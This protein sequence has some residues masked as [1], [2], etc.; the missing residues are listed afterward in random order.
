M[1]GFREAQVLSQA[2]RELVRS[3]EAHRSALETMNQQLES[4]VAVR[5]AELQ[6][7][8]LHDG[9]T[10]LPNRR[11]LYAEGNLRLARAGGRRQ[12]LLMLDLDRFKVV[13]DS[14]GH[15]AGDQLLIEVGARLRAN[16]HSDDVL[17]RLGGDEFA[18][19]LDDAGHEEAVNAAAKCVRR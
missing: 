12:A 3:E 6:S 4:T 13:N 14:L 2:M 16:L 5:T 9:L 1:N 8:L 11:A 17:A 10:G 15:H 19:L 7:L 18:I